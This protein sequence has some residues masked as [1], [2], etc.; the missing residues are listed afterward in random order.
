L[1]GVVVNL[2]FLT[3]FF[4]LV[5]VGFVTVFLIDPLDKSTVSTPF[6]LGIIL[7]ALSLRQS[8]TLVISTSVAYT[9]LTLYALITFH[10]Y[11]AAHV[12]VSPHPLFWLFQ[13]IGLFLVLCVLSIYLTHY[14]TETERILNRFRG[15][16]AKLPLPVIISDVSGNIV[17][18]NESA[19]S[20]FH[21]TADELMGKS[22]FDFVLTE[23]MKGHSIRSYFEL[24]EADT[25]SVR[26]LEITP[27]GQNNKRNAQIICLGTNPN[28]IMIT[29]LQNDE[30]HLDASLH[31]DTVAGIAA[32][33]ATS[34]QKL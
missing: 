23:A 1:W 12:H 11:I 33:F 21:Q 3:K 29:L 30:P 13:R 24:F 28:R 26:E 9:F 15:I 14:R 10:E 16:L 18:A 19:T 17:F 4:L 20:T 8:L 34:S 27:F 5:V 2:T 6:L 22:Y 31:S 25:N 7:M 32:A